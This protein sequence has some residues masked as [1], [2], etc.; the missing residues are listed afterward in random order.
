MIKIMKNAVTKEGLELLI[1][2]V[3]HIHHDNK[4]TVCFFTL[5]NGF[6]VTGTSGVVDRA[7]FKEDIGEKYAYEAAFNK[8]WEL[9]GYRLQWQILL[10]GEDGRGTLGTPD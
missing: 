3:E 5:L 6:K 10:T 7:N 1:K 2:S 9:E 8:L 4:V